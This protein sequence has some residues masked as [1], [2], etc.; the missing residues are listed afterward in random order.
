MADPWVGQLRFMGDKK[1]KKK[2]PDWVAKREG[3][4]GEAVGREHP[5]LLV[6]GV[7][8]VAA[9]ASSG[10]VKCLLDG[11]DYLHVRP[12][13]EINSDYAG[14]SQSLAS[15]WCGEGEIDAPAALNGWMDAAQSVTI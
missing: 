14:D 15:P 11:G 13:S 1:G 6:I 2:P 12:G 7:I 4:S 3:R 5:D 8:K 10:L 9:A